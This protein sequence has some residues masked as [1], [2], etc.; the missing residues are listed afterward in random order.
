MKATLRLTTMHSLVYLGGFAQISQI[1]PSHALL[2]CIY[3]S[4]DFDEHAFERVGGNSRP[5]VV[6]EL[7]SFDHSQ[8]FKRS[9]ER[10]NHS[11]R[12][13]C[14][15]IRVGNDFSIGLAAS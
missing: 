6:V 11:W 10:W 8:T 5:K 14:A 9:L 13:A 7:Q 12:L 15:I 2:V 1:L 3:S 4:T